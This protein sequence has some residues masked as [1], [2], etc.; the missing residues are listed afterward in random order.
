MGAQISLKA[1][2]PLAEILATCRKNVSNTGPRT[3]ASLTPYQSIFLDGY[4]QNGPMPKQNKTQQSAKYVHNSWDVFHTPIQWRRIE[5]DG[6][7]NHQ[8][9]RCLLNRLFRCRSKKTKKFRVTGLY[10]GN[11]LVTGEFPAQRASNAESV[12]IWWRYHALSKS[13]N[14]HIHIHTFH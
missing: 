3:V 5:R 6:A 12:F 10:E 4:W 2:M 7:S 14:L 11:S 9:H 1:A 13:K 8:P